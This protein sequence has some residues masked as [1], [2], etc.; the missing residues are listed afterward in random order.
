MAKTSPCA[1][2]RR[3]GDFSRELRGLPVGRSRAGKAREPFR[4]LS[5]QRAPGEPPEVIDVCRR[6]LEIDPY[7]EDVDRA[8]IRC[9]AT[10]SSPP[11]LDSGYR[12]RSRRLV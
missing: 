5:E 10:P 9:R 1:V 11:C 8:L 12:D 3:L 7:P 6:A 2:V 4:C